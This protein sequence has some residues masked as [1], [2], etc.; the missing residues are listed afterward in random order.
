VFGYCMFFCFFFFCHSWMCIR[1][2]KC[3][4]IPGAAI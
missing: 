2:S 4:R 3:F 1:F